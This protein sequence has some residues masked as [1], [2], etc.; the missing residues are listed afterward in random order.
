M[1]QHKTKNFK[2][3]LPFIILFLLILFLHAFT[4]LFN[5]D[6]HF[7]QMIKDNSYLGYLKMRYNT[8]TS[9]LVLETAIVN[10]V[11]WNINVWRVVDSL[12]Y[13]ITAYIMLLLINRKESS[14][15]NYIGCL[16]FLIYPFMD[17]ASAG[18]IATTTNYLWTFSFGLISFLPLILKERNIRFNKIIYLI[19][20]LS[21][22]YSSNQEQMCAIIIGFNALYLVFNYIKFK[23][24]NFYNIFCLV[25]SLAMLA[26]IFTCP[27]NEVRT[28]AEIGTWYPEYVN[29]GFLS[30]VYLGIVPTINV[31]LQNQLLI[32]LAVSI[33]AIATFIYAKY[34]FSKAIAGISMIFISGLTI[35][36]QLL[37][38]IFPTF[39]YI[40]EVF[41][42]QSMPD[43]SHRYSYLPFVLSCILIG[44][45]IYMLLVIFK[46]KK[47]LPIII[48]LA[49]IASRFILGF[50]PTV[51]ASGTRT[52][53]MLYMAIIAVILFVVYKLI[54][55]KKINKNGI[56]WL[57]S[58]LIIIAMFNYMNIFIS[59][60]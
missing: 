35:F 8:W 18:W 41:N 48:F 26:F 33:L 44:L 16:L 27:G 51:F 34:N 46:S 47:L 2:K 12:L 19:S 45:I 56:T 25:F 54:D 9:R 57:F 32:F 28:T 31:L 40:F 38:N 55:E 20:I 29:L 53:Y 23:K 11:T 3:F 17:M 43:F 30:K 14:T 6:L 21:L 1:K 39:N 15:V 7:I 5:D 4:T 36:K 13:T 22:L 49:G 10:F 37:I 52:A 60:Y 50:S 59:V 24:L 58:C 42:F